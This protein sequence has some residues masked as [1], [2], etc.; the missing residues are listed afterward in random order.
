[1]PQMLKGKGAIKNAKAAQA[2]DSGASAPAK[3]TRTGAGDESI[4][5]EMRPAQRGEWTIFREGIDQGLHPKAASKLMGDPHFEKYRGTSNQ[6]SVRLGG[7]D[8]VTFAIDEKSHEVQI[9]QIGGHS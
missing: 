5:V 2:S 8:R 7:K 9:L 1:M 4:S 6:W 3:W